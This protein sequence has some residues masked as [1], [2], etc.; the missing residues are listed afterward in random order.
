M[1]TIPHMDL[2]RLIVFAHGSLGNLPDMD[3]LMFLFPTIP[4]ILIGTIVLASA[5]RQRGLLGADDRTV[6]ITATGA[7]VAATLSTG[8]AAIHFAVVPEHMAEFV[9]FG[10]AFVAVGWFQ[11]IWAQ[12]YLLRP[13]RVIAA[14]G[15]LVSVL[16]VVV[17]LLSRSFGL[18]M[19][20]TAWTPEPI[21][22]LDAIC[23]GLRDCAR[24]SPRYRSSSRGAGQHWPANGWRSNAH[25]CLPTFCVLTVT[26]LTT[27]ALVG[28][29]AVEAGVQP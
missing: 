17:W 6:S 16:I 8:A 13:T 5:L 2:S 29:P 4:I 18:P 14:S 25:S 21:G 7:A 23:D 27:L 9:P 10:V 26:L 3:A 20:P 19:G 12:L 22:A 11:V 1:I 15:A 24:R 28:A